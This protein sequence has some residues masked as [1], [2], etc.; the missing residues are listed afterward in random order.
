MACSSQLSRHRLPGMQAR[1]VG[2]GL[3]RASTMKHQLARVSVLKMT[4]GV[5]SGASGET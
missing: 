1:R 2:N 5:N 3:G 4:G